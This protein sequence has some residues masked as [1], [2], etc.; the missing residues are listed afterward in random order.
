M[1]RNYKL[2]Q[3][4]HKQAKSEI[5]RLETL[6]RDFKKDNKFIEEELKRQSGRIRS[7]MGNIDFH[8]SKIEESK[9]Q[10]MKRIGFESP[11]T[12]EK[13]LSEKIF[14]L[15]LSSADEDY[16]ER[17]TI[18]MKNFV[19]M[20]DLIEL[21]IEDLQEQLMRNKNESST[22]LTQRE[23]W[24]DCQKKVGDLESKLITKLRSS[25]NSKIPP[26]EMSEMINST[27]QYLNNL[28]DSSDEKLTTTLI[29]NERDVLSKACEE[30]R[31]ESTTAQDGSS[32]LPSKPIDIHKSHKGSNASS[33]L[34]QPSTP[35][36][37]V[38][39]K[40][41]PKIGISESVVNANKNDAIS[42]K[43]E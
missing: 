13:S 39:S 25:S 21:K 36:F 24:L 4:S 16:N 8:L 6:L 7:E 28:L 5:I 19:H 9:H 38:A 23:L 43:V 20:K 15:R 35:S 40:S 31:S 14:N 32:A 17:Q 22:V 26:N 29:S 30:L 42:K 12:Q 11:L 27:I 2:L 3:L 1:I 10:L 37:L 41:P 33:N 18:N 34:K